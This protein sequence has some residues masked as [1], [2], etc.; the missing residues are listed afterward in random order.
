MKITLFLGNYKKCSKARQTAYY[1]FPTS[2]QKRN[3]WIN[4]SYPAEILA[5]KAFTGRKTS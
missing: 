4:F 5:M 1:P 2:L 3:L